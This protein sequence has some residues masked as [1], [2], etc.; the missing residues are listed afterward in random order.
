M[1]PR[2]RLLAALAGNETDHLPTQITFTPLAAEQAASWLGVPVNDLHAALG[3]HILDVMVDPRERTEG[4][5]SFDLWGV[6]WDSTI[7]DGF[8]IDVHPLAELDTLSGYR[9]PDPDD[10]RFYRDIQRAIAENGGRCAVFADLGFTLWERYYLLRG[11]EQ[12]MEDLASDPLLVEDV[13]DQILEVMIGISQHVVRLGIDVGYT[14]DDFGSQRGLLFSPALWR[15]LFRPRYEKLWGVFRSAG[16]PV[17]HHSCGDVRTIIGDMAETGLDLLCPVQTHA[18]PPDDLA[19]KWGRSLAFWGGICTQSVLPF[20]SPADVRRHIEHCR[21]TLGRYGRY[22]IGPSH[23]LTSD[24]PRDNL[25]TM[26]ECI[27]VDRPR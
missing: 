18:M 9:L 2:D 12:A 25:L 21:Q 7:N 20:G 5:T 10:A 23:D 1:S 6:G 19:D 11:F 17:C 13:L 14:G 27:G 8:K 15:R 22:V 24:V 3:N 26:L 4:T 16:V